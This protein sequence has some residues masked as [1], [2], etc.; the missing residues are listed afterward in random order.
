MLQVP[1][2][3]SEQKIKLDYKFI[4]NENYFCYELT[5]REN[6]ISYQLKYPD[7][8]NITAKFNPKD[9]EIYL[10]K[11]NKY[12]QQAKYWK[13]QIKGNPQTIG[14]MLP[15][16]RLDSNY[17]E[18]LS[19]NNDTEYIKKYKDVC[20]K[21]L[22]SGEYL[23]NIPNSSVLNISDIFQNIHILVI[24]KKYAENFN[25]NNYIPC[26]YKLGFVFVK[27]N[28][29][30]NIL[31]TRRILD[32]ISK[33]SNITLEKC[34]LNEDRHS[35]IIGLLTESLSATQNYLARFLML[36]Q[37]IEMYISDIQIKIFEN[38]LNLYNNKLISIQEFNHRIGEIAKEKNRITKL[39]QR[40]NCDEIKDEIK[41]LFKNLGFDCSTEDLGE[42]IYQF[43]NK[44]V[45]S[46]HEIEKEKSQIEKITDILENCIIDLLIKKPID[47]MSAIRDKAYYI[48]LQKPQNNADEN[49]YEAEKELSEDS[50]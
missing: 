20:Y 41:N 3:N 13:I 27:N 32:D 47:T 6:S 36:Y 45:H 37:V 5:N 49:W 40:I 15:S 21:L 7:K 9:Y 46:Y 28:V 17:D 19:E 2:E 33:Q 26:L 22:L 44:I 1:S 14:Y 39:F 18:E 34:Y 16:S 35:Y 29:C 11:N 31:S 25:I 30:T 12:N 24:S 42:V 43:R 50:K 48:S 10:F 38:N 4:S 8:N 23:V